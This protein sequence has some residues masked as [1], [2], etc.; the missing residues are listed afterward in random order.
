M[1]CLLAA[2]AWVGFEI[3]TRRERAIAASD[4]D[5]WRAL[6]KLEAKDPSTQM[7]ST[8]TNASCGFRTLLTIWAEADAA[9]DAYNRGETIQTRLPRVFVKKQP[10]LSPDAL[11]QTLLPVLI[12][13][14]A[15]EGLMF[16]E[17][18]VLR[19]DA[20]QALQSTPREEHLE[21]FLDSVRRQD[22]SMRDRFKSTENTTLRRFDFSDASCREA[23]LKY[24]RE[25]RHTSAFFDSWAADMGPVYISI[26]GKQLWKRR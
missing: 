24:L 1:V 23:L 20:A 13:A 15:R 19:A 26:Y 7:T 2:S 16:E 18:L 11:R 12:G 25:G 17:Y 9:L 3:G 21:R 4:L 6:V 8:C 22:K 10:T 5:H 14:L